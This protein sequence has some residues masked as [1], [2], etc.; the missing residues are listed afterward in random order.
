MDKKVSLAMP[1]IVSILLF[2]LPFCA[3]GED[4]A[5]SVYSVQISSY[6][7]LESARGDFNRVISKLPQEKL[8]H[9]RIE[10]VGEYY[11]LRLGKFPDRAAAA[12]FLKSLASDLPG[13]IIVESSYE[14]ERIRLMYRAR[15]APEEEDAQAP[16]KEQ[17]LPRA[18]SE[19]QVAPPEK[20][21]ELRAPHTEEAPPQPAPEEPEK[22]R[23][24][25]AGPSHVQPEESPVEITPPDE[26]PEKLALIEGLLQIRDYPAALQVIGKEISGRPEHPGLNAWYGMVLLKTG[27]PEEA[28]PYL[29]KASVLSPGEPDYHSAAGYCYFY[30]GEYARAADA[31]ERALALEPSHVDAL[32]GLGI[33]RVRQGDKVRARAL[34][35][36]LKSLD[37]ASAVNLLRLI[38][39]GY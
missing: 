4:A 29:T 1:A 39:G 38:E 19:D 15:G 8:D 5:E 11:A 27:R 31:F 35:D 30:L 37:R 28:L 13:A 26:L 10:T 18:A 14:Q 20:G 24:Q 22:E 6:R 12:E 33:V 2:I 21:D 36:R 7:S 16:L 17:D 32:A 3:R 23:E 34:Y 25:P 9:F